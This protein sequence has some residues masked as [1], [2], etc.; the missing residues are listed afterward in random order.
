MTANVLILPFLIPLLT[1]LVC[2]ALRGNLPLQ[3]AISVTGSALLL[4]ASVWMLVLLDQT[5]GY[6]VLYVGG[7]EA[8]FGITMVGDWLSG[9][10]VAVCALMGLAI[11]LYAIQEVD[12]RRQRLHFFPLFHFLLMGV[13]GA[14]MTGD[15]FNLY[16]WF[17]IMLISSFVL[18]VLGGDR[19]Q[20]EGGFKYVTLNLLSSGLFLAG[21][22]MLYGVTGTLNMADLSLRLTGHPDAAMVQTTAV[23]LLV[24]FGVKAALFPLYFWLPASYHTPPTAVSAIFAGLLTKVGVYALIR[25]YSLVFV[26]DAISAKE[27]LLILAAL[28]MLSGVLGAAAQFDIRRI[29]S[30]HI[31]S[32]IGY[33]V[34]GLAI[35]TPLAIAGTVFYIIHHIVVKTNLFLIGGIVEKMKG[36]GDLKRLGGLY[37][38]MP[39]LSLLFF[40]PA[41]SLGGI[42]PLS[43]FW[44]KFSLIKAGLA[45]EHYILVAVA[46]VVG[47]MTLYSMTK[48]WNEAFWKDEPKSPAEG[49]NSGEVTASMGISAAH[50]GTSS[51]GGGGLPEGAALDARPEPAWEA[52]RIAAEN[53]PKSLRAMGLM[54]WPVAA[55]SALT[56]YLSFFGQGLFSLAE[57]ASAQILNPQ[58]Y[59]E[60][61]LPPRLTGTGPVDALSK[62]EVSEDNLASSPKVKEVHAH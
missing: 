22:G 10:M 9:L 38:T 25:L 16:V 17:E 11:N 51:D 30:F 37:R 47:I 43:G 19:A 27:I 2:L 23:L 45:E 15:L 46:L 13:N 21:A 6:L 20:L 57:R 55:L 54:A 18:L 3:R 14:F 59:I 52:A 48:I 1:A 61:V 58:G 8:P 4:A 32:Q 56:L 40:I 44:A 24:S 42:P 34:L 60:A 62:G 28:T 36:T 31:V 53:R 5:G 33:M 50:E 49:V 41:F 35:F 12:E 7:W 39:Y 26:D 29:L